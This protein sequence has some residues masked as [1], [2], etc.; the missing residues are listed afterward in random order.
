MSIR[1][2]A[3]W[4][5]TYPFGRIP[6]LTQESAELAGSISTASKDCGGLVDWPRA[7]S[8]RR[9][10]MPS[11]FNMAGASAVHSRKPRLRIPDVHTSVNAAR[12]SA[13]A[14]LELDVRPEF[15]VSRKVTVVGGPEVGVLEIGGA[16][17]DIRIPGEHRMVEGVEKLRL[18]HEA[19]A[20]GDRDP[21]S[22]SYHKYTNV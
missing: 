13:C 9:E 6:T 10:T 7:S 15:D 17:N 22:A 20:L 16:T 11:A 14:T 2:V 5:R 8:N 4:H 18:Q 3:L 12:S 19:D 21:L 1:R